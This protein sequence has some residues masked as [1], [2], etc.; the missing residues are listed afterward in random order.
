MRGIFAGICKVVILRAL[1]L[2]TQVFSRVVKFRLMATVASNVRCLFLKN[3]TLTN[4][5]RQSNLFH[6]LSASK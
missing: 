2:L 6:R 1:L 5:V 4:G 3:D